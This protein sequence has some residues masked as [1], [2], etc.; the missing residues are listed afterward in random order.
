MYIPVETACKKC[1]CVKSPMPLDDW[2]IAQS[3]EIA[4][5]ATRSTIK[6][7]EGC[8]VDAHHH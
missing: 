2:A 1:Q 7:T 5:A 6:L 8:R 4:R 3:K